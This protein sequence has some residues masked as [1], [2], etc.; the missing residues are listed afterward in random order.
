MQND[1]AELQRWWP[2][3][4]KNDGI[5]GLSVDPVL[6]RTNFGPR[7]GQEDGGLN[8]ESNTAGIRIEAIS[9]DGTQPTPTA[10]T[11]VISGA[12]TLA[13]KATINHG[14]GT[15]TVVRFIAPSAEMM[16]GLSSELVRTRA[17]M[18]KVTLATETTGPFPVMMTV[19]EFAEMIDTY[20]NVGQL[21]SDKKAW[22]PHGIVGAGISPTTGGAVTANPP[23]DNDPR[24]SSNVNFSATSP[25]RATVFMP[26][27]LDMN[28][29]DRRI[30]GADN[31]I[32]TQFDPL[33]NTG[34][35]KTGVIDGI[36][37]YDAQ[38]DGVDAATIR[39]KTLG[40]SG[41]H[42]PAEIGAF[43]GSRGDSS[44]QHYN[45]PDISPDSSAAIGPKYRMRM[46]LA[47]FLKNGTYAIADGGVIIPYTYDPERVVGGKDTSTMLSLWDGLNGKG[48][49]I[50]TTLNNQ[51]RACS[52]QI[53][54]LY[55]FV[56]GP[57]A[58][59]AQSSNFD[60]SVV[61][62]EHAEW[63]KLAATFHA[64]AVATG[65]NDVPYSQPRFRLIRNNPI[66]IKVEYASRVGNFLT[67][68]CNSA[69]NSTTTPSLSF[70]QGMPFFLQGLGGLLGTGAGSA[71]KVWPAAIAGTSF[72]AARDHNGWWICNSYLMQT[73]NRVDIVAGSTGTFTGFQLIV[74]IN[75]SDAL[76]GAGNVA[77]YLTG[78]GFV[79]QG[80][81]G[82]YE[83]DDSPYPI[84]ALRAADV[85]TGKK[86]AGIGFCA[87]VGT[88]AT[89]TFSQSGHDAQSPGRQ[90]SGPRANPDS[91]T[92]V[93]SSGVKYA[94][95]SL[96][97]VSA[98]D[99]R[100]ALS[101][102][103]DASGGGVLRIPAGQGL[104][105][106]RRY[107]SVSDT[108]TINPYLEK[109]DVKTL[110]ANGF[111]V[112]S[113]WFSKGIYSPIWSYIE[114]AQGRH[115]WDNIKPLGWTYGRNRP[116]PAHERTGTRLAYTPNLQSGATNAENGWTSA[117]VVGNRVLAGEETTKYGL[118]ENACSPVW[119][120]MEI[121][122]F[123][124]NRT[125]RMVR[126]EFDTGA[127][128]PVFGRHASLFD[129]LEPEAGRG[130]IP[131]YDES[132]AVQDRT[133][134]SSSAI[135]PTTT[136]TSNRSV[137]WFWGNANY[138]AS[139]WDSTREWPFGQITAN[140]GFGSLANGYG[141]GGGFAFDEGMNTIRTVFTE[142]GMTLVA[143]GANKG[144]DTNSIGPVWGMTI[145]CGDAG[146][147][148]DGTTVDAN[149]TELRGDGPTFSKSQADLQIDTLAMRQI[150]SPA[151]LPFTVDTITQTVTGTISTYTS[152]T[153]EADNISTTKGMNITATLMTPS[154][155]S[156]E[157][158]GTAVI[159][160]YSNVE[161]SFAGGI[162]SMDLSGLP[163]SVVASGFVIRWNFYIPS[164]ADTSNHP[165]NWNAIP[166]I[167]SWTLEYDIKPTADLSVIGNTYNGDISTPIVTKVGHIISFRGTG[168]TIDPDR[169]ISQFKFD[170]GDGTSTAW[171]DAADKTL[172]STSFDTAHS[173]LDT[174]TF[175]AVCYTKDDRG[176]ESAS[177]N[178]I[179]VE[180]A[181]VPPVA[182]LRAVPSL[183][184]AGQPVT[185]DGSGSYDINPTGSVSAWLFTAG[186][187]SGTVGSGASSI[188]H[189]YAAG[190]EYRATLYVTDNSSPAG[191]SQTASTIIKVLPATLVVPLV[192]NTKPRSF[193][194][195]RS[196]LMT[197]TPVLDAIYPEV[198]DMG[199]R[200]DE[201]VLQGSFLKSTANADIAFMEELLLSG[202][203]V[204][205]VWEA[206]NFQGTPTG[207]T[208][209]GRL[210]QFDYQREG[211]AHGETPYSATFVRE[212][213]LG[214]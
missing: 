7:T 41:D 161:L 83:D 104:E 97:I 35:Y 24:E 5:G 68:W 172:Q 185:L 56:Q 36:T 126:I 119:L 31:S 210:L 15:K 99:T 71:E 3:Y 6:F 116:W 20:R 149:G 140:G 87:G 171:I 39:Y 124:P 18:G 189:T 113:R 145:E 176:N 159:A 107:Y 194:R 128:H 168:T 58:P 69:L 133:T 163:A 181:N 206:V 55:D 42:L 135:I 43:Q 16:A 70:G 73:Y 143:N 117:A 125:N 106:A 33:A 76:S 103:I 100:F 51:N 61:N 9:D 155:V 32:G 86:G 49:P 127:T 94:P 26:M 164:S 29:L 207:K 44:T 53:W 211:G 134:D 118:S 47:M 204:E 174:G 205:T 72:S 17:L 167:R 82:G 198:T 156:P 115:S 102:T 11:I 195:S 95:R 114:N 66:N 139:G 200:N 25:Y 27:L 160:G 151:M 108:T 2:A 166:I 101:P 157:A 63:P 88:P 170:F 89:T 74:R 112:S 191:V 203:L 177:S 121:R 147:A 80:L 122:A 158:E 10:P 120:D 186:D 188:Q 98:D 131:L 209:V 93:Y 81:Q 22:L 105:Y 148:S 34:G 96:S 201:F 213:G 62:G 130:Y 19:Q 180:V 214:V 132:G 67:I 85:W 90:T 202:A 1:L 78:S 154:G 152:L 37:R 153:V 196:A 21:D 165:I 175:S 111:S 12:G 28:Q 193:T 141:T 54:P 14:A 91:I 179:S 92:G 77:P 182:V 190:G 129:S 144:T 50:D 197:Q 79:C 208:F 65:D 169:L 75:S 187:G 178:V 8:D 184:R 38:P 64:A 60:Y 52:A 4:V 40:H 59:A 146:G 13:A 110:F 57:I 173:Y 138:F 109:D 46:A 212:A 183:V 150:P 199:Q 84:A 142:S 162:G 30:V 136:Y 192:L 123:I 48:E 137:V 23:L 45:T